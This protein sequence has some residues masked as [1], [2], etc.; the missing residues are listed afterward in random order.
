MT[1]LGLLMH[2]RAIPGTEILSNLR[3][4]MEGLN[5]GANSDAT[6]KP[7]KKDKNGLNGAAHLK[8]FTSG[9]KCDAEGNGTR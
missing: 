9:K 7:A 3:E 1:A 5:K 4:K 2:S 6:Q 8:D